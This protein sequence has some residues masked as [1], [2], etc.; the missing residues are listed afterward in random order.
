MTEG[1]GL[2][3]SSKGSPALM[4]G[5]FMEA[6]AVPR[7]QLS[8]RG[9]VSKKMAVL[10]MAIGYLCLVAILASAPVWNQI[11]LP[12]QDSLAVCTDFGGSR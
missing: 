3:V 6:Q 1:I 2:S 11:V 8:C 4:D 12:Y 10:G 9:R 5:S 7:P